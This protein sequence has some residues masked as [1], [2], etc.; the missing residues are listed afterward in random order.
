MKTFRTAL[1]TMA[2]LSS[3][4]MQA[5]GQ[6][7]LRLDEAKTSV[8]PILYGM[9]TEEINFAYEGGLYAQ[10]LRNVSFRDAQNGKR[11]NPW[12]PWKPEG[13][14]FWSVSILAFACSLKAFIKI[15]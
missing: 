8:S 12:T 10:L 2:F 15:S 3:I 5:Q 7:T 11:P 4:G 9:M 1:A 6:M 14:K 13:A